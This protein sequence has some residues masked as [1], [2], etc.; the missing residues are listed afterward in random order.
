MQHFAIVSASATVSLVQQSPPCHTPQF[1]RGGA[2]VH[3]CSE[4][5]RI[6]KITPLIVIWSDKRRHLES[7][8]LKLEILLNNPKN[9]QIKKH[10]CIYIYN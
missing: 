4:K 5:Q 10:I 8:T 1:S 9:Q 3:R 7:R 2:D 6:C